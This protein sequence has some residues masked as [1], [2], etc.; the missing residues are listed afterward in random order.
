[1]CG[2]L[3]TRR[4]GSVE[5]QTSPSDAQAAVARALS[6]PRWDFRT[7]EG[8]AGDLGFNPEIVKEILLEFV[9]QEIARESLVPDPDGRKLF[10][11]ADRAASAKERLAELRFFVSKGS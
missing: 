6:D 7:V 2:R 8:I 10:A 1:M 9:E 4:N 3:K 11:P 5:H